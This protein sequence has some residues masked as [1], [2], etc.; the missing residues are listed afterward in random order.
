LNVR[1]SPLRFGD[2]SNL[3]SGNPGFS[4]GIATDAN[5]N[6]SEFSADLL[7]SN[8]PA[9]SALFSGP[10]VWRTNGF[11]FNLTFT[12]N[13][14]YRIQ[15]TTKLATNPIPWIDLTNYSASNSALTFTDRAATNFRARFYRAVSP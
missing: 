6:T 2:A 15:A 4:Y 11:I 8:L 10:M 12:T 1:H 3:I 7:A 13:F 9:P 14:G 5:G